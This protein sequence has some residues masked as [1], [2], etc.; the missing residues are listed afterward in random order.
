[1]TI[2]EIVAELRDRHRRGK[3]ILPYPHPAL[4]R[5]CVP[6][7]RFD[8]LAEVTAVMF[9]VMYANDGIG[10]AAPQVGLPWRL[11][12][13]NV[14]RPGTKEMVFVNPVVVQR[15]V[16]VKIDVEGCLS[17]PGVIAQV[18]RADTVRVEAWDVTGRPFKRQYTGLPAR[19]V[20]H[21]VTHLDGGLILDPSADEM[22]ALE[23]IYRAA[24]WPPDE[25]EAARLDLLEGVVR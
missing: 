6:V 14:G 16:R 12:V 20:Q 18:A 9:E 19:C 25:D 4:R 13:M 17:L 8:G 1:M 24:G 5:R 2:Q 15:P 3:V 7:T 22:V 21:E 23:A 10:L 11:F